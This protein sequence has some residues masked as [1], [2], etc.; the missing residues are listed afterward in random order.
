M[1][2]VIDQQVN[3]T[4]GL[5]QTEVKKWYGSVVNSKKGEPVVARPP[6]LVQL[7]IN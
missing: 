4:G 1:T 7:L 6:T 3:I 2:T 5:G